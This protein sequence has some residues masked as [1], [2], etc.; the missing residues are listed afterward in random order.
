VA[1]LFFKVALTQFDSATMK[2]IKNFLVVLLC[3]LYLPAAYAAGDLDIGTS[4]LASGAYDLDRRILGTSQQGAGNVA[5]IYQQQLDDE[6]LGNVAEIRQITAGVANNYALIIQSGHNLSAHVVQQDGDTNVIRLMQVGVG[7]S[8][9]L[10][11]IGGANNVMTVMMQG[12]NAAIN[13]TQTYATN[14]VLNVFLES[15]ANLTINQA[16]NGNN[17]T[18]RL[19][20]NTIMTV[21]QSSPAQ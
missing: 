7:H 15:G 1:T 5:S 10:S 17:F 20:T 19:A 21:N 8:A 12:E 18:T 16:G 3:A 13:A 14:S 6:D 2:T 11:Q 9:Y 4:D